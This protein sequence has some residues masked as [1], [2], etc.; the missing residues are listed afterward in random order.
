MGEVK[1]VQTA[2]QKRI[3]AAKLRVAVIAVCNAACDDCIMRTDPDRP[4]C[5]A[6]NCSIYP[7]VVEVIERAKARLRPLRPP[8]C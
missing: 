4:E 3:S 5:D 2:R 6:I 1:A 7:L 8:H